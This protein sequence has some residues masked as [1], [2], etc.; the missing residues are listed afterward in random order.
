MMKRIH[1]F[2]A[3][4]AVA[5]SIVASQA[6]PAG[7]LATLKEAAAGMFHVGAAINTRQITEQDKKGVAVVERHFDSITP[8]N[9]M[10]WEEIHPKPNEYD[11]ELADKY[12]EFGEKRGLFIIGHTLMWHSQTPRWVFENENGEPVEKDVLMERLR[13]HIRTVVGR[14]KGRVKGWDVVNEAVTDSNGNVR[15]ERP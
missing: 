11:F 8:E 9:V 6:A 5:S 1:S 4:I 13:D 14:Y 15:F 10:K 2:T 7:K 12:V 3:A